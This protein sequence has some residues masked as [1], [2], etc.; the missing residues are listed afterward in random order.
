[1][2]MQ[3]RETDKVIAFAQE[4]RKIQDSGEEAKTILATS[5]RVLARITDGIYRQPSSAL[6]ELISN[7]YDAD[8]TEV[9]IQTDAL[10]LKNNN[11][12]QWQWN[13]A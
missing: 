13:D 6:R 2:K 8:A 12:R 11:S 1:M 3:D 5:D 7:G 10:V 4:L 9:I